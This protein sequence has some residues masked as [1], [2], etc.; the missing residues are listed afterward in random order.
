MDLCPPKLEEFGSLRLSPVGRVISKIMSVAP[1]LIAALNGIDSYK[2]A[3][4][5]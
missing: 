5:S 4:R 3:S 1:S 2:D